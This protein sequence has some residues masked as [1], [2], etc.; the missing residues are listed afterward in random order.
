MDEARLMEKLR[1][2]EALFTDAATEGERPRPTGPNNTSWSG[3]DAG[4]R[5]NRRAGNLIGPPCA[6]RSR[7]RGNFRKQPHE[8]PF[9]PIQA[10]ETQQT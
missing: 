3:C 9:K 10:Q 1:L 8:A 4:K 6:I 2:T 5:K 7:W